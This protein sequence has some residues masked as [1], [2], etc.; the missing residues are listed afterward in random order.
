MRQ[1]EEDGHKYVGILET[2]KIEE[3]KMKVKF[4]KEHLRLKLILKSKL[5][6]KNKI[7]AINS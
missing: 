7:A 6:V 3:S 2:D 1:I 5:N 4:G